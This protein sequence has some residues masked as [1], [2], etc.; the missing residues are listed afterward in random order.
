[1][2]VR[3]LHD[4]ILVERIEEQDRTKGGI[5]IPDSAKEKPAEGL[6][7]AVGSGR[8]GKDGKVTKLDVKAGDHILFS[9]YAGTEVKIGGDELIIM[10]EDSVLAVIEK[11][12]S[13]K[14]K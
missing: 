12:K 6:V 7:K 2:K 9:K 1:M 10:D 14:K 4:K 11:T 8:I 13:K 3:P 5:Y